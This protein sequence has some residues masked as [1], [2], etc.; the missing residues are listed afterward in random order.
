VLKIGK[1]VILMEE[2][3]AISATNFILFLGS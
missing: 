1:I 3:D 2:Y